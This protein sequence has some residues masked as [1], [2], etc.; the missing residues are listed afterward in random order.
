[1]SEARTPRKGEPRQ[2]VTFVDST[3]SLRRHQ[4]DKSGLFKPQDD[5]DEAGMDLFG[6]A[7]HKSKGGKKAADGAMAE[8]DQAEPETAEE[9]AEMPADD[10]E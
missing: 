1:M 3:G 6:L 9:P 4:A 2:T 7:E 8:A 5:E 10:K